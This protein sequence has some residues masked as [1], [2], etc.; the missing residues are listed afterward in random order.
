ME[1]DYD[2]SS[3][4]YAADLEDPAVVGRRAGERAVRRLN[5]RKVAT[6]R[7]PVVFDPRVAGSLLRHLV[8]AISGPAVARGT[9]F[10]KDKRGERV[11]AAGITII[12]DPHKQRGLRSK[13]FDAEGVRNVRR[14]IVD[15]GVLADLAPR[16][17]LGAPAR[18][19]DRPAMPAAAPAARPAR[20]RPI[21]GSSPAPSPPA[22]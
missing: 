6:C 8:G 3:A 14:A 4:V 11:F 7:V 20:R 22:S 1:R 17:C 13:P 9:S 5:A 19:Q 18:P 16:S 15:D 10:L 21:C 2:Y 12:D